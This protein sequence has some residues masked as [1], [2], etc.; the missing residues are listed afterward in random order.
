MIEMLCDTN[1]DTWYFWEIKYVFYF[2]ALSTIDRV[3]KV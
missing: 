3:S 2:E 1:Q